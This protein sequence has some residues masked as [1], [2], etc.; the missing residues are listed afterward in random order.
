MPS[1]ARCDEQTGRRWRAPIVTG[2]T[3][4]LAM[5][6]RR[7]RDSFQ[8][9]GR[10]D[11]HGDLRCELIK[12]L[13]TM[14]PPRVVC[15]PLTR[16]ARQRASLP[17]I[18]DLFSTSPNI[19]VSSSLAVDLA[20]NRCA[21]HHGWL[22][23]IEWTMPTR[24]PSSTGI[25][26]PDGAFG[27]RSSE[28]RAGRSPAGVQERRPYSTRTCSKPSERTRLFTVRATES[29]AR[30]RMPASSAAAFKVCSAACR[31]RVSSDSR[32]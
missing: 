3:R 23:S 5:Q 30:S 7:A 15:A 31:A 12:I 22:E 10:S 20:G 29:S 28:P 9:H 11:T 21:M 4:M 26:R 1:L 27:R 8:F 19:A 2:T 24:P 16:G 32:R 25:S 18:N 14:L 17:H 13:P 6:M